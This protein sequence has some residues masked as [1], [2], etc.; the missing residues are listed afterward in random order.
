MLGVR[1]G[2][3]VSC[4][5]RQLAR[6]LESDLVLKSVVERIEKR[7]DGSPR[8]RQVICKSLIINHDSGRFLA[9]A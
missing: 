3:A 4:Q 5:L 7:L 2:V 1:T 6:L 9:H 8:D